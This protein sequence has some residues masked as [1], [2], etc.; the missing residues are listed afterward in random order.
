MAD[1][2]DPKVSQRYRELGAEEPPRRLDDAILAVSRRRWR[3]GA[4]LAAAAVI[5]L[6]VAVTWHMRVEEPDPYGYTASAPEEQKAKQEPVDQP[7]DAPGARPAAPPPE[8]AASR[9]EERT[10]EERRRPAAPVAGA[11]APQADALFSKQLAEEPPEKVLERI[12]EMRKQGRHEEADKALDE[13]R[14]RY[15]DH[16]LPDS[17]LK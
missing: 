5:V 12:A 15:P 9:M 3:W 13:F 17:V 7:R 14:K 1:E 11:R 4:P 8:A 6:S 10:S 16:K 2:R